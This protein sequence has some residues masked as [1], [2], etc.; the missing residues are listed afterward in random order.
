MALYVINNPGVLR[1]WV[2]SPQQLVDFAHVFSYHLLV[3]Q[4]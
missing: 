1:G 3:L 2:M 4:A